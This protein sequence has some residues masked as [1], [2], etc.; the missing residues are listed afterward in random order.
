MKKTG[1]VAT[2]LLRQLINCSSIK[3]VHIKFGEPLYKLSSLSNSNLKTFLHSHEWLSE[4]SLV[5]WFAFFQYFS[6]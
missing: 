1:L 6:D 5:G 4:L 2:T 3:R